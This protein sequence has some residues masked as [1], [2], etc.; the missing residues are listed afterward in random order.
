MRG[1]D[2]TVAV[3]TGGG[4]GLGR[5][6][7]VELAKEG[8]KVA[9]PDIDLAGA[10]ATAQT[11]TD[12][13]GEA[14]ALE[15]DVADSS[16]VQGMVAQVLERYGT[17]DILINNAGLVG[18]LLPVHEV[19][20]E[21]WDR[22]MGVDL[23]G[24]FLCSKYV[25][26]TMLA[27]GRGVIINIASVSGFLASATGVEYTS[28][29]HGVTGLTKQTAYDYGHLGIRCVGVGPGVI[30]TP[31]TAEWNPRRAARSTS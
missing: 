10:R 25:I 30:E 6:F 16:S 24:V 7:S 18:E 20:E 2:G 17:I 19:S 23:K 1:L 8:V 29:K 4:S 15:A 27:A 28:A 22:V 3:I 9:V 14:F 11:I 31:L 21:S 26:P 12:V 13:G 5:D